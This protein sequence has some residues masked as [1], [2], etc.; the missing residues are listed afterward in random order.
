M[1]RSSI[2][3]PPV[4][5]ISLLSLVLCLGCYLPAAETDE[6]APP[7]VSHSQQPKIAEEDLPIAELTDELLNQVKLQKPDACWQAVSRL[8]RLGEH[9]PVVT[10]RLE[11]ELLARDFRSRLVAARALCQLNNIDRAAGVLTSLVEKGETPEA[12]RLAANAIG[13][14]GSLYNNETV[15][16]ALATALK[17]ETDEL[18]R[19]SIARSLWR[20]ASTR[21]DGKEALLQ[22]LNQSQDKSVKDEAALVLAENG[23][24]SLQEVRVRLLNLYSEP[25]PAGERAFNLLRH[26]E[27][28]SIRVNVS[29]SKVTQ[30][31]QLMRELLRTIRA[32]YPDESKIDLDRLFEDAAKGMVAGLDPFSQY[33]DRD[34]VKATQEMLQQDYGG[35]GAYVVQ[36]NNNFV[37]VSPIYG[38]PADRAGLRAQDII[39]EVDGIKAN[40]LMDKGGMNTVIARLKGPAGTPVKVK[41]WRRGFAKSVEIT[42]IR[43]NIRIDSVTS[44]MLPGQI[45]YIKLTRFGEHSADEV[46]KALDTLFKEQHAR[47][48]IF[49]LRDNPGGLLRAGVDIADKFLNSDKLIV[50][51]EGN[52][53][54]APRKPYMTTGTGSEDF[55]MVVL[56][57]GGS[58]SASEIVA[59]AMQDHKRALLIGE[60]T[61]GK[62]SVQQIMPVKTTERQ[63][64]LRL[65][66]AKYYLPT[67]RC[68]HEKGIE[69]DVEIKQPETQSWVVEKILELR[70]Q[71]VFDD[72]IRDHWDTGKSVFEKLANNDD[73]NPQAWPEFETFYKSL[74]TKLEPSDVRT[75]LR[76]CARHRVQDEQKREMVYDFVEDDVLQRGAYELLKSLKVDPAQ[77]AE[78]KLLPE[79]FNKKKD[80]PAQEGAMLPE[81]SKTPP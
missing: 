40:E 1:K 67:G 5:I 38:S 46:Q 10:E 16:D 22:I 44:A 26:A 68:I 72:Y 6:V 31:E 17:S 81:S 51:S 50:Y 45:A 54:F 53:D 8:V 19:I 32:A 61:F 42:I 39:Q 63:T 80:E 37:V 4:K 30:G 77:I 75:E 70:K 69:P 28:D 52:K 78:Y 25:T 56:V 9:S 24:L 36:R 64:Q 21:K 13:L 71:A 7:E 33:M 11:K 34:E 15:I 27:E 79:K 58:A 57:G 76:Q 14:T 60:K 47:G 2:V 20:I 49:D 29:D 41:F 74:N 35:I 55:P 73:K 66:V 62:G 23:S 43:E 65:T 3:F 12:R 48:L 18:T 59:G